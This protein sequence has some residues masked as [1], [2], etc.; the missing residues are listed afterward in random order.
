MVFILFQDSVQIAALPRRTLRLDKDSSNYREAL[1][2]AIEVK[3]VNQVH[4]GI[5][6]SLEVHQASLLSQSWILDNFVPIK[7]DV[8][9]L[10]SQETLHIIMR[11]KR[12]PSKKDQDDLLHSDIKMISD[13]NSNIISV[14]EVPYSNFVTNFTSTFHDNGISDISNVPDILNKDDE[15]IDS[16]LVIRWKAYVTENGGNQRVAVGQHH[17]NLDK[18][19]V[20]VSSQYD[21]DLS[22]SIE[23]SLKFNQ[24]EGNL[25]NSILHSN[26]SPLDERLVT[27]T[28]EHQ[29]EV[30]HDFKSQF[31]CLVPVNLHLVNCS[32]KDVIVIINTN[33][34]RYFSIFLFKKN[35]F[36]FTIT[37]FFLNSS[38]NKCPG[39]GWIGIGGNDTGGAQLSLPALK[40][41]MIPLRI[42]CTSPGTYLLGNII[43]VSCK[44][45][46]GDTISN[47][48]LQ[49]HIAS[50]TL[51]VMQSV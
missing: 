43:R 31:I 22:K 40:S 34:K 45:H 30:V 51:I 4:H 6:T 2:L 18:L 29:F 50:S 35:D 24:T 16:V 9:T 19:N 15:N 33:S 46:K 42:A 38:I 26:F 48:I 12:M 47:S 28:L 8:Q 20:K 25:S 5:L 49:G 41:D 37:L 7:E 1:N 39:F 44:I 13:S 14:K 17:I 32:T 10:S 21:S 3:N 23:N 27:F 11:S 36:S